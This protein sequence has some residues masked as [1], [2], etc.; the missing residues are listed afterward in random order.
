MGSPVTSSNT[1]QLSVTDKWGNGCSFICS[2]YQDFGTG[3]IPNGCGFTL[4]NRGS[5][6]SLEQG[7]PN[8]IKG[9]KRPY[10]TIIP[11]IA[12]KG[13]ELWLTFGCMGGFMQPQGHVQILL[14]MLR[15]FS[16]QQ[17]VDAPRFCVQ[18]DEDADGNSI[19]FFEDTFEPEV[20]TELQEMGHAVQVVSGTARSL[21]GR[22]QL[23]ER[24]VHIDGVVWGAGSDPRGDGHAVAEI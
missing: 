15:G 10:H 8:E 24:S 3:A 12:T 16:P 14:S 6:F 17:A 22:A 20:V 13:D 18:V 5:S 21:M 9:G 19:I 23:I 7:H 2:N 1:V 11:A 4:Q